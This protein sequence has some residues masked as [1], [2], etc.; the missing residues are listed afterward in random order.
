MK[1][2]LFLFAAMSFY[3]V[4]AQ[5][6]NGGMQNQRQ[7]QSMNAPENKPKPNF[8]VEQYLGIVVYDIE[9]T[10][11]KIGVKT[12]SDEGKSFS[13][14]LIDYNKKIKEIKRINTFTLNSTKEMVEN[15]QKNVI[16]NRD[17]SNQAEVQK[18]LENNLKS[19]SETLKKEDQ[20]LDADIKK[21]LSEKQHQKWIKYNK[22]FNK[23]FAEE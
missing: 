9:K 10:A 17:Y 13:K 4:S 18:K 2:L 11:K 21:I 6:M 14:I 8:N 15:F 23:T 16:N 5:Y 3:T 22:K 12:P 19:V 1:K 7:R 20:K